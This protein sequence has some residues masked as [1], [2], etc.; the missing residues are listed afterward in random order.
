MRPRG[1]V[2]SFYW[3]GTQAALSETPKPLQSHLAHAHLAMAS[4]T[5]ESLSVHF[6]ILCLICLCL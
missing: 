1:L 2:R 3:E 4:E 5:A 6:S